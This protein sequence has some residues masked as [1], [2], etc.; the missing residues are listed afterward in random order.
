MIDQRTATQIA[1]LIA[2]FGFIACLKMLSSPR[3]ARLGNRIGSASMLLAI[4]VTL[5][6]QSVV[7]Y[8]QIGLGLAAGTVI[9]LVSARRVQMTQMPQ[10]V[11]LFN[12]AGGLGS[13]IVSALQF[14]GARPGG[15]DTANGL[16]IALG[17]LIGAVAFSGSVIAWAKLEGRVYTRAFRYRLQQPVNLLLL[18]GI[19]AS[20]TAVTLDV[21]DRT[22]MMV[23]LVALSTLLGIAVTMPSS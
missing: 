15:V 12:G 6:D 11:A 21:G 3:T 10:M 19:L 14:V 5:W 8:G 16:S 1:Y 22:L 7:D 20:G 2:A 18:L 4:I 17:A 13:A 23:V 9:G